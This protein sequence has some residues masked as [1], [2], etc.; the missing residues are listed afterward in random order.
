MQIVNVVQQDNLRL[1]N[2]A[3]SST[4]R[5]SWHEWPFNSICMHSVSHTLSMHTTCHSQKV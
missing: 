5:N 4:V 2:C 3:S 1:Q